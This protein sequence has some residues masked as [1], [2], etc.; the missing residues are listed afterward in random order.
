MI[1]LH[2]VFSDYV[3]LTNHLQSIILCQSRM[4]TMTLENP[5]QN[6]NGLIIIG[7]S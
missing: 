2:S 7:I 4:I 6:I 3:W 1:G 5:V